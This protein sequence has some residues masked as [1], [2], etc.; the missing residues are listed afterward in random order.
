MQYRIVVGSYRTFAIALATV[1]ITL[2]WSVP[3]LPVSASNTPDPSTVTI[4]GSLQSELGCSGDWQPDCSNTYLT[5]DSEDDIWQGTF[6]IPAGSWEYKV[7]LNDSWDE[8]YGL[9]AVQNGANIPLVL[10]TD[11][12]VKFYYDHETHW[13]T[14]NVSSIIATVAGSF[15]SE[16]GCAGD[17]DPG[18]LRSWLQDPDG[19]GTYSFAA[20]LPAGSYECKVAIDE[21][22]DENYGQE[23]VQNGSNIP[24]TVAA[25]GLVLF[26]YNPT[27]HILTVTTYDDDPGSI[28]VWKFHDS[29]ANGIL[30]AGEEIVPG[31]WVTVTDPEGVNTMVPTTTIVTAL[32]PGDWTLTEA[33]VAGTVRT[34]FYIDAVPMIPSAADPVSVTVAGIPGEMHDVG[35]GNVGLGE[36]T[37]CKV[38]DSNNNGVADEGE[39]S[40]RGWKMELNGTLAN[41]MAYG[42]VGQ[43]THEDGCTTFRGLLPG[44]Y[45]ITEIIPSTGSWLSAGPALYSFSISSTLTGSVISGNSFEFTFAN[46][47]ACFD[48]KGYW[49]SKGGLSELYADPDFAALLAYIN[50]LDPYDDPSGYFNNGEEPFDGYDDSGNPV[51]PAIASF[52]DL[53]LVYNEISQFLVDPNGRR[54]GGRRGQLA[55]LL[56]A[57]I[58]NVNC[59]LNDPANIVL[60]PDNT[61]MSANDVISAGVNAWGTST[62][63]DDKYWKSILDYLNNNDSG[64]CAVAYDTIGWANLQWP[65]TISHIIS[66]TNGTDNAYGQVWI[67]GV[68]NQPGQSPML[69]AQLGFGPEGSDPADNQEWTWV[70]ASFNVDAG[71]NDE[72][73][74][75]MLPETTG[76]FDY[77]YRYTTTDGLDWLYADLNGPIPEG[78]LPANPGKLA[79]ISSGDSTPP[80]IPSGL[81]V[82]GASPA[83]ISLTWDALIGDATLYGYEVAR[84][85]SSGGPYTMIAR[86]TGNSY[87]DTSVVEEETYYYVVRSVDTSFNRSPH[88]SPIQV[89]AALRTVT[90]TFD[91]TVPTTTDATGL[92]VC[93]T[94]GLSHLDGGLPDWDPGGVV[95]TRVD[96]THWTIVLTGEEW[97]QIE[98][99]F[100]LGS[101]DY[102]EKGAGC[103]ELCNRQFILTYGSDGLQT[104]DDTVLNWRNVSPC[105]S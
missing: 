103:E 8:N 16:I 80:G 30:D 7:A 6:S 17:W 83:M 24:F 29:N 34:V 98:Y 100:T 74:A 33:T 20:S 44:D 31:W 63:S 26:S 93:I 104:V 82:T 84:R 101:W 88:S 5:Y 47:C 51:P 73:I 27:S 37:A 59:R 53:A 65:P 76:S 75:S 19:D 95:L 2:L 90:M 41:G 18:C 56:L 62:T 39:P 9:N 55:Q 60:L 81:G 35:F 13:V 46:Y 32:T 54:G 66:V 10:A 71:N 92:S 85:D 79:V 45:T 21:S 11:T 91:V 4:V 52:D 89:T 40:I 97:T 94:G 70:E 25:D 43:F 72:F 58:F 64:V 61:W 22:W 36:V 12:F 38:Y 87:I 67:D 14:D 42:P 102:V 49:H 28:A 1:L 23:G 69:R 50:N 78:S 96:A 77:V 3:V 86:L 68:T 15:Q 105:G 48:S 57:F 99:K